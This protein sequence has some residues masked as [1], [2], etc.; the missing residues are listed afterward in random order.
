MRVLRPERKEAGKI[1]DL[2]EW[3]ELAG[4]GGLHGGGLEERWMER[5]NVNQLASLYELP[6]DQVPV[7][8]IDLIWG[9]DLH[10]GLA[11]T[12]LVK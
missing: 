8:V 4:G 2:G 6:P 5:R 7:P 12:E 11:F 10:R 3:E 9:P 1:P